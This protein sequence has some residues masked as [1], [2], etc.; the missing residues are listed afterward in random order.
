VEAQ[1]ITLRAADGRATTFEHAWS[2]RSYA[3]ERGCTIIDKRTGNVT[4]P[5]E[6]GECLR[7]VLFDEHLPAA[8]RY[9]LTPDQLAFLRH[10]G[11]GL[12]GLENKGKDS[13]PSA[14]DNG[15]NVMFP[16]ARFYHK[17]GVISR[18]ALEVACVDDTAAS[19]KRFIAVP[20]IAAGEDTKPVDGEKLI[21]EM[22]RAI[23]E[24]V[25]TR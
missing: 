4:S 12:T 21:G 19:G 15:F 23:G 16:Q 1:R 20:V 22:S 11:A 17:C 3:E 18:Y 10:G 24:W 6:L 7:R 13:S 14:W 5:R 9:R 2:G 25:K 8:D